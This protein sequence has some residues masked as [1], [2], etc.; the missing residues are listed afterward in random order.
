MSFKDSALWKQVFG[1]KKKSGK[2]ARNWLANALD[3]ARAHAE[4]L[5]AEIARDHPNFTVHDIRHVDALWEVASLIVGKGYDVNPAE[6]FV[7]GTAFLLHD[8]G[9]SLAAY[10]GRVAELQNDP[11]YRELLVIEARKTGQDMRDERDAAASPADSALRDKVMRQFL[12]ERHADQA[13]ALATKS[14]TSNSATYHII[15]DD[16]LREKC[17]DLIGRIAASH[18][19]DIHDLEARLPQK[20]GALDRCPPEW[21]IDSVKLACI[22]RTADANQL[23]DRRAPLFLRALRNIDGPSA[24]HWTFQARLTKPVAV[25]EQLTHTSTTTFPPEDAAAWWLCFDAVQTADREL[26]QVDALLHSTRRT[27]FPVR[28]VA[29]ASDARAMAT[30]IQTT[31]WVPV[32]TRARVSDV[33]K[34][35]RQLGGNRLYGDDLRVPL[36]ELI[37]NA[38][39][40]VRA[41]RLIEGRADSWGSITL[42]L[43]PAPHGGEMLEVRDNGIGMTQAVLIGELLDFGH[44]YWGSALQRSEHGSLFASGFEPVGEFGI[45]FF[46][47]FMLASRVD[48]ITRPLSG[49]KADTLILRFSRGLDTPPLLLQAAAEEQMADAGTCVRL[50]LEGGYRHYLENIVDDNQ[51]DIGGLARLIRYL[52]PALDVTIDVSLPSEH[53]TTVRALTAND[54]VTIDFAELLDRATLDGVPYAKKANLT[55]TVISANGRPIARLGTPRSHAAR[56]GIVAVGGCRA[57]AVQCTVPGLVVAREPAVDRATANPLIN[58]RQ[59]K[60]WLRAEATAVRKA[61]LDDA[62]TASL[63]LHYG[64][65]PGGFRCFATSLEAEADHMSY[66]ML[67]NSDALRQLGEIAI[68][69]GTSFEIEVNGRFPVTLDLIEEIEELAVERTRDFVIAETH[70]ARLFQSPGLQ[71]SGRRKSRRALLRRYA[72]QAILRN[73]GI[74]SA[75]V[76]NAIAA[77]AD[78]PVHIGDYELDNGDSEDVTVSGVLLNRDELLAAHA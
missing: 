35:I 59:I 9:M 29:Y 61:G 32:D 6:G 21:H 55:S 71:G 60:N 13:I 57:S 15:E 2:D 22:L 74:K 19:W 30:C 40:A 54:W 14:F 41:R 25:G 62:W 37:Q 69:S 45:G 53:P 76:L 66:E 78:V 70:T 27:R 46:S 12:R 77:Q 68:L 23:D 16:Y 36:R 51:Q 43:G 65:R 7:L 44:S 56:L 5:A 10:G 63:Y 47:V 39:D 75:R 52:S 18:A 49:S 42:T 20:I 8:L 11:A 34:L 26:R 64:L 67:V 48:V 24:D 4:E 38:T 28:G 17:G 58:E 50:T 1:G 73:W 3:A 33:V 72:M 31:G